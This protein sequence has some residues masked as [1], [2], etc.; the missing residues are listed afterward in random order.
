MALAP[1][2]A[3]QKLVFSTP[4]VTGAVYAC[5]ATFFAWA[6]DTLRYEEHMFRAIVLAGMNLGSNVINAWWAIVFYGASM[7][8]WFTLTE[9]LQRGMWAMIAVSIAL[10]VWTGG[11]SY[12]T[13]RHE[14]M[15]KTELNVEGHRGEEKSRLA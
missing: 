10:V 15:R 12:F 7:A 5:Q 2:Y 3:G 8:P 14:R 4:A 1:K 13:A 11:L 6:N 9:D